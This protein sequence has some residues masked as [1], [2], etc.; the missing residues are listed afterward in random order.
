[1]KNITI[2][3]FALIALLATV[4]AKEADTTAT[5]VEAKYSNKKSVEASNELKQ[6]LNFGFANTSGNTETVNANGKYDLSFTT[7]GYNEN[8]LKV[9]FD[10]RAFFTKNNGVKSDEEYG[11]NLELE[12]LVSDGWLGYVGLNWLRNPDFR[13]YDNKSSI[14]IGLGKELY[15]EGKHL[16][17]AK[18]G[19][20]YNIEEFANDQSSK[21]FGSLNEYLEYNNKLNSISKLYLKVGSLQNF[22]HFDE[23]YEAMG[24]LGLNFAVGENVSLSIEEEILYDNLPA[25][26]FEKTDTKS[27]VRLGYNF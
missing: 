7:K 8:S 15:N 11:A 13:N 1:M 4:E 24:V 16:L 3:L 21:D 26:G 20:A 14:N 17:V 9:L 12:Q 19:T 27:I 22:N 6:S 5:D 10:T 23:D 25:V 18:I 2:S